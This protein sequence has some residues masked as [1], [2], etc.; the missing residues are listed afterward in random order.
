[1]VAVLIGGGAFYFSQFSG[2]GFFSVTYDQAAFGQMATSTAVNNPAVFAAT[3]IR[4]PIQVK[5]LYMTSWVAGNQKRR[6]ELVKLIDETELNSVVIDIKDYTGMIAFKVEDPYLKEI[7]TVENRIPDVRDFIKK[8]HDKNI[9]VVGRV[10]VFQDPA[11]V[12]KRPDLAVKKMSDQT[13]V[14]HDFK[15][16]SWLDAGETEVWKYAVALGEESYKSGFDEINFDYVRFPSDGNMKDIFYPKSQGKVKADVLREFFAYIHENLKPKGPMISADLFGMTTTNT[17]DLNIGQLLENVLP[18][19]D[20]VAPMVYPSH[21]PVGFMNFA[22][23][24][25]KPYEVVKYS[26]DKAFERAS[27]TPQ[28]LRPWLQDFDLGAVYTP[29]M[30]RAQIQAVYD[31]GLDS[32]MLWDASNR[33]TSEALNAE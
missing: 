5:A 29:E 12:K 25:E 16:I 23:P 15:G 10:S 27:T 17:D 28:K 33:Y 4:T 18:F 11:L 2:P 20:Y 30:V 7:G 24:A 6:A 19:V 26:M 31:S 21:Y 22:K 9:Y 14:W 13:A 32:W 3:H 8:L 1:M